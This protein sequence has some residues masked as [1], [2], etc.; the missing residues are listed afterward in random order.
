M[1]FTLKSDKTVHL[2]ATIVILAFTFISE[3]FKYSIEFSKVSQILQL[4]LLLIA[5]ACLKIRQ[6]TQIRNSRHFC[7][8]WA[9]FELMIFIW[10]YVLELV[11][12]KKIKFF[13][14]FP[15][16]HHF[17]PM[18]CNELMQKHYGNLRFDIFGLSKAFSFW[19]ITIIYYYI[20]YSYKSNEYTLESP[21]A[22]L[23]SKQIQIIYFFKLP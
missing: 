1:S 18:E 6:T 13:A 10:R 22:A 5:Q 19:A 15:S 16:L 8:F 12:S 20:Y 21:P 3:A 7:S 9:G 14:L 4:I 11:S 17:R 23:D 2:E